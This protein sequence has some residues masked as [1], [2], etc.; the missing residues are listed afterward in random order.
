MVRKRYSMRCGHLEWSAYVL[1]S[2][3]FAFKYE[4]KASVLSRGVLVQ[5]VFFPPKRVLG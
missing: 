3:I 5:F 1:I 4:F 2:M